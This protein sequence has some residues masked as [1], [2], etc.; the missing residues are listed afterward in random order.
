MKQWFDKHFSMNRKELQGL[1]FLTILIVFLWF[2][3][4]LY[5]LVVPP[6]QN[7]NFA[8]RETEIRNFLSKNTDRNTGLQQSGTQKEDLIHV[9]NQTKKKPEYFS[10]NPNKLKLEEGQRLGLSDYQIRMIQN[11][12]SK[13]GQFYK[14]EDLAKIYSITDDDFHRLF[15]YI[16]IPEQTFKR[17]VFNEENNKKRNIDVGDSQEGLL[18]IELNKTDSIELQLLKGIG[19]VYASRIIRFRDL[20]GGFHDKS[21]L[22]QVYG[23]DEERYSHLQEQ[24]YVDTTYVQ[25]L[26]INKVDYQ[27][28]AKHPHITSK[29]ANVIVQY[30]NQHG[31]YSR[32]EDLLE[33]AIINEEFLRKIAPYLTFADD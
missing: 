28:L 25:K 11:Y 30:R 8:L 12:V 7:A 26:N 31:S 17:K 10:F 14:K 29:Q 6:P 15:P 5:R 16:N 20:L 21:Q 18:S 24:V 9:P 1:S 32:P 33:I 22:L 23:M 2:L 4:S 13:G 27:Q 19:P 3:P